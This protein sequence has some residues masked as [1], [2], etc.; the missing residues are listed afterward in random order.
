MSEWRIFVRTKPRFADHR[1]ASLKKEW[2]AA[3]LK[4]LKGVRAGQ[5]YA[6]S[7]VERDAAVRLAE[8]LLAD[9]VTQDAEIVPADGVKAPKGARLAQ[10]WPR[11]GVSDP[12]AETVRMA[13]EDL[14]I[15]GVSGVRSGQVYEFAG[16]AR[17]A[18]IRR[19]CE[20][21]LMNS[22]IQAVEVL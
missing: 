17:P 21:R 7:G 18:D 4:A 3:G 10:V 20:E 8:R 19:F 14:D 22:L 2:A 9:P 13:A 5:A 15:A 1:G 12:V 16:A 11:S 6:L